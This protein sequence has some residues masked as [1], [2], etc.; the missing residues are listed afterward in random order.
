MAGGDAAFDRQHGLAL[1]A[2]VAKAHRIAVDGGIV[3]ERQ[4]DRRRQ[5]LRQEAALGFDQ[6][7]GFGFNNRWDA[8]EEK[9][10]RVFDRHGAVSG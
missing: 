6:R 9:P 8:R 1:L 3:E 7:N 5:R 2:E 10:H 4:I